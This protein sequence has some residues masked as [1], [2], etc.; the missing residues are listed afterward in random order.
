[1]YTRR[2]HVSYKFPKLPIDEKKY[3]SKKWKASRLKYLADQFG[4]PP[5]L[6]VMVG[7]AEKDLQGAKEAGMKVIVVPNI[8]TQTQDFSLAD[9]MFRSLKDI[10][11]DSLM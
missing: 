6:C 11:V 4:L 1:M 10:T 2:M 9:G 5:D 7:D 8:Y 3:G